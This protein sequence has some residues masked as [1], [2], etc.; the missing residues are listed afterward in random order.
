ML[1]TN[2]CTKVHGTWRTLK[3]GAKSAV[4]C[5]EASTQISAQLLCVPVDHASNLYIRNLNTVLATD[6]FA[7]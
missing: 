5:E 1:H 4:G 3:S 6:G 7:K 2:S